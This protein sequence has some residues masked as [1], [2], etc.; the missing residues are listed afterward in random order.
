MPNLV[1]E[2]SVVAANALMQ[3]AENLSTL[4]GPVIAGVGIVL[5]GPGTVYVLNAVSFLI[6]AFL[7]VRISSRF[8]SSIAGPHRPHAL[9]GGARRACRSCATTTISRRSS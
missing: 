5:L 3:G 8:Q 2:D 1:K 6:S 7:L 9:A 4:F